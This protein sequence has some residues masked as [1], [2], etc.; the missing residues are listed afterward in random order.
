MDLE[1]SRCFVVRRGHALCGLVTPPEA[2]GLPPND[3]L[4]QPNALWWAASP[5]PMIGVRS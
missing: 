1:T 3:A 5:P 4:Q 2:Y